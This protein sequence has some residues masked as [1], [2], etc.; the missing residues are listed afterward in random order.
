DSACNLWVAD[1][2][3]KRVLE[4]LAGT[5]DLTAPLN[6]QVPIVSGYSAILVIIAVSISAVIATTVLLVRRRTLKRP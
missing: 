5:A 4:F 6:E 1:T 2:S 3:N